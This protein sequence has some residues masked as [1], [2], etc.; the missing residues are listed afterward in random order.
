MNLKGKSEIMDHIKNRIRISINKHLALVRGI[1][2]KTENQI[3]ETSLIWYLFIK[4]YTQST[5]SYIEGVLME[6]K[7]FDYHFMGSTLFKTSSLS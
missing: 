5:S 1:L 4:T 7:A 2:E 6:W 3:P